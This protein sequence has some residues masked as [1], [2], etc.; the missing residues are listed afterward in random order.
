VITNK[1]NIRKNLNR[2]DIYLS[3]IIS[4]CLLLMGKLFQFA[5]DLRPIADDYC[6]M[7][8]TSSGP[9]EATIAYFKSVNGDIWAMFMFSTLVGWSLNLFGYS[10]GSAI[11]FLL[12]LTMLSVIL[13]TLTLKKIMNP[14]QF[15]NFVFIALSSVLSWII[16][17]GGARLIDSGFRF[18][19][20]QNLILMSEAILHWKTVQ[21]TYLFIPFSLLMGLYLLSTSKLGKVS[22]VSLRTFLMFLIGVSGYI[23]AVTVVLT[24][25]LFLLYTSR[26]SKF[27]VKMFGVTL[28]PLIT[29]L[30]ISFFSKGSQNRKRALVDYPQLDISIYEGMK[31]SALTFLSLFLNFGTFL[32]FLC[33]IAIYFISLSCRGNFDLMQI[34]YAQ[35]LASTALLSCFTVTSVANNFVGWSPWHM[36]T[37]FGIAWCWTVLSGMR[38][39]DRLIKVPKEPIV[40]SFFL[41]LLFVIL[42]YRC[43]EV[44]GKSIDER[45]SR[46]NVGP[47]STAGIV[48]REVDWVVSCISKADS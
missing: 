9:I 19:H 23:F 13:P 5:F 21:V 10:V 14:T 44:M 31:H 24:W 43:V 4:A 26:S 40:F 33:G 41:A 25:L 32:S 7:A 46:W 37:T 34:K 6:V 45:L 38:L 15:L 30:F 39:A 20:E 11:P 42:S 12:L 3:L 36:L 47:A 27:S 29:G 22:K 28:L 17:W 8:N 16:F 18:Q 35:R 48:D 1:F 2:K